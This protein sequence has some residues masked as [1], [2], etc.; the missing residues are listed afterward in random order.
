[1][2]AL[3]LTGVAALV[4][5]LLAAAWPAVLTVGHPFRW[6]LIGLSVA[7]VGFFLIRI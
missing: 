4:C 1:M 2:L 3:N 6:V 7:T 5:G